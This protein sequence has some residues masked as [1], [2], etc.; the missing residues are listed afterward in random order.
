MYVEQANDWEH[1]ESMRMWRE[2]MA[3]MR[4]PAG[5]FAQARQAAESGYAINQ[6]AGTVHAVIKVHNDQLARD[7][8]R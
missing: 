1:L 4:D 8:M 2:A 7:L 6:L 3:K 5:P